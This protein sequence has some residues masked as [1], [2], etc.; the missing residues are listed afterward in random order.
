MQTVFAAQQRSVF[1]TEIRSVVITGASSGIGEA[2]AASYARPGAV[3]GLIGRDSERLDTVAARCRSSGA[4]VRTALIDVRDAAALANWL[5][6]FDR[7]APIDLLIANAGVYTGVP[8]RDELE[9][10]GA[11]SLLMQ[12]NVL[13]VMNTV[14]PVLPLMLGRRP[15]R[16]ALISSIAGLAPLPDAPAYSAS[17]AAVLRYGLALRDCVYDTGVRVN[18]VCPGYI[19]SPMSLRVKGWKPL[20]MSTDAAAGR[21]VRAL[22]RDRP[23]TAFPWPLALVTRLSVLLPDKLRRVGMRPFRFRVAPPG[24]G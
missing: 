12:I 18:V 19:T 4:E 8:R 14:Q 5:A 24:S 13:G 10:A 17:K 21:I 16:I 20:E 15:G 6:E 2:L 11:A 9:D 3:L 7:A 1:V 22:A 23:V